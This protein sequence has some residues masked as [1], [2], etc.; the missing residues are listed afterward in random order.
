M[1]AKMISRHCWMTISFTWCL[2][3]SQLAPLSALPLSAHL[4]N[5]LTPHHHHHHLGHLGQLWPL[6]ISQ[7]SSPLPI[8]PP[9]LP[10]WSQHPT[11]PSLSMASLLLLVLHLLLLHLVLQLDQDHRFLWSILLSTWLVVC[12]R[13]W[14]SFY[15]LH[16]KIEF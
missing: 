13:L 12:A 2:M 1:L 16:L 6:L 7:T 15:V 8:P 3:Q 11:H 4:S 10:R 14:S 9:Q 5:L